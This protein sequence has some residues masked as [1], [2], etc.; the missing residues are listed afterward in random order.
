MGNYIM[1]R[2]TVTDVGQRIKDVRLNLRL[3]QKEM[4]AALQMAPSYL[5]EIE[6]GKANPGPEFFLKLVYEYKVNPNYL[7]LGVGGMFLDQ[8][9]KIQEEEFDLVGGDIDSLEKLLWVI[10]NSPYF[11]NALLSEASRI[12]LENEDIII[13]SIQKN[14]P[15][16]EKKT[17]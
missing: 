5:S 9:L 7:F 15:R 4:A 17:D 3:Q 8:D 16:K 13:K 1:K 6:G 14:K 10:H 12:F 11:R 2:E